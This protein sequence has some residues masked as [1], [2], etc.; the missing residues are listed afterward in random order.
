MSTLR[1]VITVNAEDG[2]AGEL[3]A[4]MG[5][6]LARG[7]LGVMAVAMER[8]RERERERAAPAHPPPST[9]S[10]VKR[11]ALTKKGTIDRRFRKARGSG[12]STTALVV[13]RLKTGPASWSQLRDILVEHG[14]SSGSINSAVG[15]LRVHGTV[16]QD[17]NKT[18]RLVDSAPALEGAPA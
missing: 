14:F 13:E 4:L 12:P 5:K 9:T 18:F 8:E 3:I 7:E 16:V 17:A 11:L 2:G 1:L 6:A 10:G 15:R